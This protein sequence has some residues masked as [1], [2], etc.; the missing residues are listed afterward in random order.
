[1]AT[2][3]V[4]NIGASPND[5]EGDPLRTAFQ[6]VNNNFASMWASNF[7]TLESKTFSSDAVKNIEDIQKGG[8]DC[9]GQYFKLIRFPMYLHNPKG[10]NFLYLTNAK[11]HFLK[12]S[13]NILNIIKDVNPNWGYRC[14][15]FILPV[16]HH[17]RGKPCC[18]IG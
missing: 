15:K 2:L 3:E 18:S 12:C 14:L 17:Q 16:F 13:F 5:G 11:S 4:I 9:E 7:N 6:K 1:M 10:F 8:F